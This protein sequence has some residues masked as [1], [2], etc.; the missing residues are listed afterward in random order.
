MNLLQ[1]LGIN[2]EGFIYNL[3]S[4]FV[5]SDAPALF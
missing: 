3:L 1:A 4:K 5:L 2:E